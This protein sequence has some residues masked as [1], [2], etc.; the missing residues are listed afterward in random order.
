MLTDAEFNLFKN[1]P[2]A[3]HAGWDADSHDHRLKLYEHGA[4]QFRASDCDGNEV[5]TFQRAWNHADLLN[6]RHY[7]DHL[8]FCVVRL[9]QTFY[10]ID[11]VIARKLKLV[12]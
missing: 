10:V 6:E 8:S 5:A 7:E 2:N 11:K 4:D 3:E 9:G 1:C 12:P